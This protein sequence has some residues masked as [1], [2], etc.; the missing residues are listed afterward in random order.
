MW[1]NNCIIYQVYIRS[2]GVGFK[3]L[4]K[5]IPHWKNLG[6]DAIWL[7]PFA[8]HGG[9]DGGYD[10]TNMMAISPEYGTLKDFKAFC[11]ECSSN[12]IRI[13]IDL[14]FNHISKDSELFKDHPEYFI[15]K[16]EEE[17][18][19]LNLRSEFVASPW[20]FDARMGKYYYHFFYPEQPDLDLTNTDVQKYLRSVIRFWANLGIDGI[21][22]D[23]ASHYMEDFELGIQSNAPSNFEFC[24]LL[25]SW[26]DTVSKETG[27]EL[28][29]ISELNPATSLEDQDKYSKYFHLNMNFG[30][31]SL[32]SEEQE[33]KS[34]PT[35]VNFINNHDISRRNEKWLFEKLFA[36]DGAVILYYGDEFGFTNLP[37]TSK[38]LAYPEI[39]ELYRQPINISILDSLTGEHKMRL[40]FMKQLILKKKQR[41]LRP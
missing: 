34:L 6:I 8:C 4:K 14:I 15:W 37:N 17:I 5:W 2:Y 7:N 35:S 29:L 32:K 26:C 18:S 38:N 40:R 21:R 9:K 30:L 41:K 10:Q 13:I 39:R 20:T 1:Y 36:L 31:H 22:F 11:K 23:A 33:H 25:R 19:K 12:G 28:I 27:K 16:T 3:G 24:G